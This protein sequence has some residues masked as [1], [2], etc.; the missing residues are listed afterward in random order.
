MTEIHLYFV[1][2]LSDQGQPLSWL[3]LDTNLGSVV[4]VFTTAEAANRFV[5][6]PA[7]QRLMEQGGGGRKAIVENTAAS[8]EAWLSETRTLDRSAQN[9]TFLLDTDPTW[10]ALSAQIR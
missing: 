1:I 3:T 8:F 7:M 2:N 5:M 4:P 10:H 6:S 9:I